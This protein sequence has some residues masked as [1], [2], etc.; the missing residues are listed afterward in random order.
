MARIGTNMSVEVENTLATGKAVSAITKANP[1]VATA[2]GHGYSNGDIVVF[3]VTAGMVELDGQA[4]RVA[5]VSTAAATFQ[6][7]GLDT[8]AYSTFTAG[9][10]YKVSAW[11]TLAGAQNLTMPNPAPAKID[12]TTLIDKTKQYAYGLPDA[13]DGTISGLYDPTSAAVVEIKAATKAN[14]DRVFRINWA[15]GQETIFNANVSGG[16]GFNLQQNQAATADIVF[17]PV[18]DVL[19]YAS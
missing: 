18:K 7:E 10:S 9:T 6:L 16:T 15:G 14:E 2:T 3:S 5:N 17:T 4:V 12:I 13:P 19:D 1:G 8:T 11:H